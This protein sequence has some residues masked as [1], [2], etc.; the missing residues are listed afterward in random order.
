MTLIFDTGFVD[1]VTPLNNRHVATRQFVRKEG[2][3]GDY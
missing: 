1:T 3:L 2:Y